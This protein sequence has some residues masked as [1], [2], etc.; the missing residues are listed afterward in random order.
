MP[1]SEFGHARRDSLEGFLSRPGSRGQPNSLQHRRR[2]KQ[3]AA[4]PQI[5]EHRPDDG[6]AAIRGPGRVGAHTKAGAPVRQT[7]APQSQIPLQLDGVFAAGLVSLRI[8]GEQRRIDRD[9]LRDEDDHWCRRRLR[10][11]QHAT[12]MAKRAKLNGEAQPIARTTPGTYE[13]QIVGTEHIMAGH[14]GR[15]GRDREQADSLLGRQQGARGHVGLRLAVGT[16][17]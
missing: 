6:F 2:R 10:Q 15:I 9:L 7:E 5:G 13:S 12:R 4:R 14:L 8:V 17:S 16:R 1:R 11:V 3:D